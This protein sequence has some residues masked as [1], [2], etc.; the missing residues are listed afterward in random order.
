MIRLVALIAGVVLLV[1]WWSMHVSTGTVIAT[2]KSQMP[3]N[4]AIREDTGE[5]TAGE[6]A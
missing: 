3:P 2:I 4:P 6:G 5:V 1:L